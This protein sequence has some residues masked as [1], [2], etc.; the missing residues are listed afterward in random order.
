MRNHILVTG[1]TGTVGAEVVRIL[2]RRG[3]PVLAA[4]RDPARFAA[5]EGRS[6]EIRTFDFEKPETWDAAFQEVRKL[7]LIRPP[8]LSKVRQ[9]FQPLLDAAR[10]AGVEHV[11]F[12]SLLGAEK[13][14]W[15]PHRRIERAIE[16]SGMRWTFLRP[17]FFMQNL[18]TTHLEDIRDDDE[19]FVP[20]GKGK[21][22][23]V[24]ARD[25]AEISA[26][27]LTQPGF[28]SRAF[29][30]TGPEALD[31][32]E[33]AAIFGEVLGRPITYPEPSDL[34]FFRRMRKRG[35]PI[36]FIAVMIGIYATCRFGMSGR[37]TKDAATLLG[38]PPRSVRQ[39]VE[40]FRDLWTRP[41]A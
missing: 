17:G 10:Q 21:T 14:L 24:D 30:L 7:F 40:D 25:L 31:Y 15:V 8:A 37:V 41:E 23:F 27:A 12:L 39:F 20:A 34:A 11:V 38:R 3:A 6:V 33:V 26:L 9:V 5:P 1:A 32:Y 22:S 13:S 36:G 4:A 19:I 35:H 18:S 28:H 2:A 29:P 16:R